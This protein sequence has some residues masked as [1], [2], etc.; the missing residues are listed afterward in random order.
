M[1]LCIDDD[2]IRYEKLV[3]A[4][5]YQV[6][7]TCRQVDVRFYLNNYG[8]KIIGI[9]LDHD[10]PFENGMWYADLLTAYS[11]PI[12][13]VSHNPDAARAMA[14]KLDDF[15]VP[16]TRLAARDDIDWAEAVMYF[17]NVRSK[18]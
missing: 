12:V 14:F 6:V 8:D 15:D 9:C 17:F 1:I 18:R 4:T 11:I 3:K 16:Q 7:V 13:I 2:P 10:M 5:D